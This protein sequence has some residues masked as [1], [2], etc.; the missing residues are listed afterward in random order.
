M[1]PKIG[2][3]SLFGTNYPVEFVAFDQKI[4]GQPYCAITSVYF[5]VAENVSSLNFG[6]ESGK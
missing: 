1:V 6:I 5:E 2:V 4:F 3:H